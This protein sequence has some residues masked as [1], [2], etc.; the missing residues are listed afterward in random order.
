MLQWREP[1]G[2]MLR[3]ICRERFSAQEY[4]IHGINCHYLYL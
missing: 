2:V 3:E 1:I 4:I